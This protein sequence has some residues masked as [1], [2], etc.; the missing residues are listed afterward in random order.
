[1]SAFGLKIETKIRTKIKQ[2]EWIWNNFPL[3]GYAELKVLQLSES[4]VK[5]L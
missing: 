2:P 5:Q 3:I 1:L 4:M